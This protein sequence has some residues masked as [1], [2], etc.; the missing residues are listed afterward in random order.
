VKDLVLK[1]AGEEKK[2]RKKTK[3]VDGTHDLS[4][5]NPQTKESGVGLLKGQKGTQEIGG[6]GKR[7]K[8]IKETLA[9]ISS[10]VGFV[11]RN[12]GLLTCLG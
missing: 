10:W 8:K 1:R 12:R 4:D 3:T 2:S 7:M 5:G 11:F 9:G 6:G